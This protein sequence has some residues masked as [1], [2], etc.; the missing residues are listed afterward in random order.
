M[1]NFSVPQ[2]TPLADCKTLLD[3]ND[4][5]EQGLVRCLG[6]GLVPDLHFNTNRCW[7]ISV[8]LSIDK[9]FLHDQTFKT[10]PTSLGKYLSSISWRKIVGNEQWIANTQT[11]VK[12]LFLLVKSKLF[13]ACGLKQFTTRWKSL[14]TSKSYLN[15]KFIQTWK[16][17]ISVFLKV[18]FTQ[19]RG[20]YCIKKICYK[21]VLSAK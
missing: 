6:L 2:A 19:R 18:F 12:F 14:Y 1:K 5:R 17:S 11:L 13:L 4:L 9:W 8:S 15:I 7:Y 16:M 21:T 10:I 3:C 20:S